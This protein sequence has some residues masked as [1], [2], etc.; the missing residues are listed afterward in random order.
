LP[1]RFG[2][3]YVKIVIGTAMIARTFEWGLV[4]LA[5]VVGSGCSVVEDIGLSHDTAAELSVGDL[6]AQAGLELYQSGHCDQALAELRKAA[7][8]PLV[9]IEK[10]VVLAHLGVCYENAGMLE[11]AVL[12]H[13]RAIELDPAYSKAWG[14][15]GIA[16]RKQG[17]M[18]AAR[19]CYERAVALDPNNDQALASLG[20]WFILDDHPLE[21]VRVLE[22]AVAIDGSYPTPHANLA[23]AYAELGREDDAQRSVSTAARLGYPSA[24]LAALRG[25]VASAGAN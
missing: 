13:R 4:I 20:T 1:D 12:A 14:Y 2:L 15:L 24:K 11:A 19:R 16:R 17:Q 3:R 21:A 7:E 23:V 25:R 8:L 22:R 18:E 10:K 9:T 5:G 6:H